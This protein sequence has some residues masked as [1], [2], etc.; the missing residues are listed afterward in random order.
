M[1]SWFK[2]QR[3]LISDMLR[4]MG[5]ANLVYMDFSLIEF[6]ERVA[7]RDLVGAAKEQMTY[8]YANGG[9]SAGSRAPPLSQYLGVEEEKSSV[10]DPKSLGCTTLYSTL[11]IA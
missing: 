7:R 5:L 9:R 6:S 1:L 8:W 10:G 4:L 3:F 11:N 2:L